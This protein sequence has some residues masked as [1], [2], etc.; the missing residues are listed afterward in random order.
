MDDHQEPD[1]IAGGRAD[2]AVKSRGRRRSRWLLA[3]GAF[4]VLG[5]AV[6]TGQLR[7]S[8]ADGPPLHAPAVG[9]TP[10]SAPPRHAPFERTTLPPAPAHV[11]LELG[12]GKPRGR[13][14]LTVEPMLVEATCL[15]PGTLLIELNGKYWFSHSCRPARVRVGERDVT[16]ARLRAFDVGGPDDIRVRVTARVSPATQWRLSVRPRFVTGGDPAELTPP[17]PPTASAPASTTPAST[18]PAFTARQ[19]TSPGQRYD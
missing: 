9:P 12:P 7:L 4:V 2:D 5:A 18:N 8:S 17:T 15:G 6:S 3:V 14:D 11:V 1:I 13:F 19:P 16:A 10:T